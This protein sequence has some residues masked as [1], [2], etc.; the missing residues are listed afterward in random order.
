MT[1]IASRAPI[2]VDFAKAAARWNELGFSGKA[3]KGREFARHEPVQSAGCSATELNP[4]LRM[5]SLRPFGVDNRLKLVHLG[6][7]RGI[8]RNDI[9]TERNE[10]LHHRGLLLRRQ[11]ENFA[12]VGKP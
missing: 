3:G 5:T 12:F 9:G 8:L 6:L 7:H 10:A 2:L 4:F 11:I 1:S